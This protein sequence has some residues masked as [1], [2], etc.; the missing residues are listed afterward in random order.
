MSRNLAK[1]NAPNGSHSFELP[2]VATGSRI[3]RTTIVVSAEIDLN[4]EI[5]RIKKGCSKNDV[6]KEALRKYLIDEGFDP[7]KPPKNLGVTY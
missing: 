5:C 7:T 1:L 2:T 4:L 6:V 3:V